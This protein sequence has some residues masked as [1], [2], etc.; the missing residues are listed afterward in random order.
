MHSFTKILNIIPQWYLGI[1]YFTHTN[2][3]TPSVKATIPFL[4]CTNSDWDSYSLEAWCCLRLARNSIQ[5]FWADRSLYQEVP[6][7]TLVNSSGYE[8][9]SGRW[10]PLWI[11]HCAAGIVSTQRELGRRQWNAYGPPQ[12]HYTTCNG[13]ETCECNL[14][15]RGILL[16][17]PT[18]DEQSDAKVIEA[19]QLSVAYCHQPVRG[20]L[21]EFQ[22]TVDTGVMPTACNVQLLLSRSLQRGSRRRLPEESE[23]D[24]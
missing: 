2:E 10:E 7:M 11:V 12:W 24:R 20:R 17:P 5:N 23:K 16:Q 14:E 19:G 21:G 9:W 13:S 1:I 3:M 6:K 4:L 15:V 18:T 22:I 8:T